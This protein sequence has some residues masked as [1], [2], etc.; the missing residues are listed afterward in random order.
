[1]GHLNMPYVTAN[2][3]IFTMMRCVISRHNL[4]VIAQSR[5]FKESIEMIVVI[6]SSPISNKT[7]RLSAEC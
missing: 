7:K 6:F 2:T 1:M 3:L 5:K 4:R